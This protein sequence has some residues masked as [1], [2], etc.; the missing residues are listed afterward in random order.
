MQIL[1]DRF[2]LLNALI[3]DT[4]QFQFFVLVSFDYTF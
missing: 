3:N 1:L 2:A 4:S